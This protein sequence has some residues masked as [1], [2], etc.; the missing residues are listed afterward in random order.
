MAAIVYGLTLLSLIM[1]IGLL[2]LRGQFWR[3]D[4]KLEV[5]ETVLESIPTICVVI[6]ARNEAELLPITLR[7]LLN[8]D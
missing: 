1:W 6:P 8:Q 5:A 2:S 4:Q 3:T 7:S